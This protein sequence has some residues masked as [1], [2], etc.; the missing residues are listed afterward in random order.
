VT[1]QRAWT[2]SPQPSPERLALLKEFRA[3]H[4]RLAEPSNDP[5]LA[6]VATTSLRELLAR[7]QPPPT[8]KPEWFGLGDPA[9]DNDHVLAPVFLVRA[10]TQDE[11][12]GTVRFTRAFEGRDAAHGGAIALFFDEVLG[13]LLNNTEPPSRTAYLHIDYRRLT[14][15]NQNIDFDCRIARRE[16][17]KRLMHGSL[18]LGGEIL[19]EAE[20]L[21][22]LARQAQRDGRPDAA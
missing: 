21:W 5:V 3:L 7:Y 9:R 12:S 2:D 8:E 22:V 11:A 4:D 19:A 17:R 13:R 18:R 10:L 15:L 20:G 6:L 16:G 14:P 1:D